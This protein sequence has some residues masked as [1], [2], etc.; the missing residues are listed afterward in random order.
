METPNSLFFELLETAKIEGAIP[1]SGK[2]LVNREAA[3]LFAHLFKRLEY[4]ME[5]FCEWPPDNLSQETG[6]EEACF[7]AVFDYGSLS[8]LFNSDGRKYIKACGRKLTS[9][10]LFLGVHTLAGCDSESGDSGISSQFV[11]LF[12]IFVEDFT[13][14]SA[15]PRGLGRGTSGDPEIFLSIWRRL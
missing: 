4:E 10:G 8:R 14:V 9:G 12:D 2:I 15:G 5:V 11:D 3:S 13:L 6:F 7:I 1:S